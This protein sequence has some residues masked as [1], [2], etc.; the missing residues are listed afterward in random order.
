VTTISSQKEN[1]SHHHTMLSLH[2]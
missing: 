2:Q 1:L